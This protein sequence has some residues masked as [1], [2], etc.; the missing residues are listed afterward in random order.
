MSA[1]ALIPDADRADGMRRLRAEV[2]SGEWEHRW[3]RLLG[4]DEPTSRQIPGRAGRL[5]AVR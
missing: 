5:P 4:V 1:L 3:S 2:E